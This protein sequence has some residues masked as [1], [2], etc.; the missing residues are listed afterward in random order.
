MSNVHRGQVDGVPFLYGSGYLGPDSD[1][2][3]RYVAQLFISNR[4]AE[5]PQHQPQ[6]VNSISEECARCTLTHCKGKNLHGLMF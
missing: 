5:V 2:T 4:K 1:P 6:Y 3:S